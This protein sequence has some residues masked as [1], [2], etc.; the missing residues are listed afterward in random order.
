MRRSTDTHTRLQTSSR[1][2]NVMPLDSRTVRTT[3]MTTA[4]NQN[5]SDV[6]NVVTNLHDKTFELISITLYRIIIVIT[7]IVFT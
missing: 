4:E 3:T 5:K 1:S 2:S 6:T 7:I